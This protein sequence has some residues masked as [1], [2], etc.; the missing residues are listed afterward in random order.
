MAKIIKY[1][2]TQKKNLKRHMESVYDNVTAMGVSS[3]RSQ[4]IVKFLNKFKPPFLDNVTYP[5]DQCEYKATQKRNL[6]IHIESIHDNVTYSCDQCEYK[7]TRKENLKRHI[8][9]IHNNITYSC[10]ECTFKATRKHNLKIHNE[11]IHGN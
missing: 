9:N 5:C 2:I 7:V 11:S 1:K 8:E 3:K 6:K 4:Y 10:D